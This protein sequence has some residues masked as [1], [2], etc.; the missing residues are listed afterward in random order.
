[1][2]SFRNKRA[3]LAARLRN[4]GLL[5]LLERRAARPGLAVLC[6]HRIGEPESD[7]FY[8]PLISATPEAF[9]E[10]LRLVQAR[11]R[12]IGLPELLE[13]LDGERLRLDGPTA[14]ITFDDGYRDNLDLAVPVLQRL[15]V[16]AAVF[17]TTGFALQ[18]RLPWWDHVAWVLKHAALRRF[19]IERPE[20]LAVDCH[21]DVR[22]ALAAVIAAYLRA[23]EPDAPALRAHLEERAGVTADPERLMPRL[24]LDRS[25]LRRLAATG[26]VA[27][28]AHTTTHR[29]LGDLAP[30]AQRSE[31][32]EPCQAL[33]SVLGRPVTTLA[34]PYGDPASADATTRALARAAG[35]R[36]GFALRPGLV[37]PDAPFDPLDVPRFNVMAADPPVLLRARLALTGALGHSRL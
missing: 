14:L 13:R 34:Y 1:M 25:G 15:G 28:G 37:R 36:L 20:P 8:D 30:E 11:Y 23:P 12:M 26:V 22:A 35:Y 29:R 21:T 32:L 27:I 3:F 17:V 24:F 19:R 18:G 33:E 10:T 4:L 31:L 16:P 2:P 9:A 7:P 5:R 6:Y